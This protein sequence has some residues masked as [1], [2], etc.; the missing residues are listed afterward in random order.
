MNNWY[1]RR[2]LGQSFAIFLNSDMNGKD[3]LLLQEALQQVSEQLRLLS[4]FTKNGYPNKTGK[5]PTKRNEVKG[6]LY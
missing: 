4:S 6:M 3:F 1:S 2:Y 5:I